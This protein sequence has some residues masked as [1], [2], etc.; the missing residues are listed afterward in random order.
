MRRG[1]NWSTK[2]K[3][4]QSKGELNPQ[5]MSMLGFEPGPYLSETSAL[6][7]TC[8]LPNMYEYEENQKKKPFIKFEQQQCAH[9]CLISQIIIF[10]GVDY[11]P[12]LMFSVKDVIHP[13]R[14]AAI[15]FPL[16][17]ARMLH[18]LFFTMG[19]GLSAWW[20]LGIRNEEDGYFTK[21]SKKYVD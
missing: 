17:P 3:T 21:V 20:F 13:S 5:I 16:H 2:R 15:L 7:T 19:G 10:F 1:E 6:T 18:I 11:S 4:S 9:L 12:H 14:V 8:L